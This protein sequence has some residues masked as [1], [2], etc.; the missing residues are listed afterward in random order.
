M[1]IS[2]EI[3]VNGECALNAYRARGSRSLQDRALEKQLFDILYRLEDRVDY[4]GPTPLRHKLSELLVQM[5]TEIWKFDQQKW[6]GSD[7][8]N[9]D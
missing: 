4:I 7:D 2:E 6:E 9:C 5:R 1:Q 3:E 8:G